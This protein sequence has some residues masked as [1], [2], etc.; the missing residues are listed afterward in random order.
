MRGPGLSLALSHIRG[1]MQARTLWARGEGTVIGAGVHKK[2]ACEQK[3]QGHPDKRAMHLSQKQDRPE[4]RPAGDQIGDLGG[5]DTAR[6]AQERHITRIGQRSGQARNANGH[7]CG[8]QTCG[9]KRR[10]RGPCDRPHDQRRHDGTAQQR[11]HRAHLRARDMGDKGAFQRIAQRREGRDQH[12]DHRNRIGQRRAGHDKDGHRHRPQHK[13]H[14]ARGLEA[15][16]PQRQRETQ[17]KHRHERGE[18]GVD[19]RRNI[20]Q[21]PVARQMRGGDAKD[22]DGEVEEQRGRSNRQPD[23]PACGQD[24]GHDRD[25]D[26]TLGE[27]DGKRAD[28][29]QPRNPHHRRAKPPERPD[30]DKGQH[31]KNRAQGGGRSSK[32]HGGRVLLGDMGQGSRETGAKARGSRP[33]LP[34]LAHLGSIGEATSPARRIFVLADSTRRTPSTLLHDAPCALAL[35]CGGR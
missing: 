35:S 31:G 24:G 25:T 10:T 26:Q 13:A 19:T 5:K 3:R 32:G 29:F 11:L 1:G 27:D 6:P 8:G 23:T 12:E 17:R 28:P 18:H 4:H 21:R 34:A 30:A 7:K 20:A 16:D 22:A 9:Q 15:F 33:S 2:Q 14:T